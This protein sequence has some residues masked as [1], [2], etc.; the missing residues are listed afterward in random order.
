MS[1]KIAAKKPLAGLSCR[2]TIAS[3]S[4]LETFESRVTELYI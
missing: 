4:T 3:L 1:K 2:K